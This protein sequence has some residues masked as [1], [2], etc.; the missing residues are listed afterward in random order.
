MVSL[1]SAQDARFGGGANELTIITEIKPGRPA[2]SV[3]TYKQQLEKVLESIRSREM[4]GI[5]TPIRLVSTIHFA[6]WIIWSAEGRDRLIFT[7]NY[8]GSMWQYLRDFSSLIATDMDRVWG[9]CKGYPVGGC[10]DFDAFWHYVLD[11]QVETSC[12]FAALPTQSLRQREAQ[13]KFSA[14]FNHFVAEHY[15]TGQSDPAKFYQA[16]QQ[17]LTENHSYRAD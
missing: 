10:S 1:Q 6:R 14:A 12:F 2:G 15:T 13:T 11:H 9:K 3:L 4:A 17:F 7:S 16:F 8:D 5:A